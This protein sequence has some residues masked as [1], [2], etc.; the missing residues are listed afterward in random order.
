MKTTMSRIVVVS[1]FGLSLVQMSCLPPEPAHSGVRAAQTWGEEANGL[2]CSLQCTKQQV[3]EEQVAELILRVRNVGKAA[4][5]YHVS[6]CCGPTFKVVA[7]FQ[8]GFVLDFADLVQ[9]EHH[10]CGVINWIDLR[11]GETKEHKLALRVGQFLGQRYMFVGPELGAQLDHYGRLT[12]GIIVDNV[13]SNTVGM[14]IEE[15]KP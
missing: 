11:A 12:V 5:K 9:Q 6:S 3:S 14:E 1:L 7:T 10:P 13:Q 4:R 8:D 2:Q 15:E